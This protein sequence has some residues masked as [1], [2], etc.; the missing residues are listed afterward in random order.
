MIDPCILSLI[1][2]VITILVALLSH[3]IVLAMCLGI[4]SGALILEHSGF[5]ST[6]KNLWYYFYITFS[7]MERLKIALFLLLV[8][9]LL[10]IISHSGAYI[11][12]AKKLAKYLNSARKVRL[13]TFILGIL[14]FFDD[15][16]SVLIAGTSMRSITEEKKI[17]PALMAYIVDS[18]ATVVSIT[19]L[20]TWSAFESSLMVSSAQAA[21]IKKTAVDLLLSSLPY[22]ICTYCGIFLAFLV[23]LTGKWF[24]KRFEHKELQ[25]KKEE[26]IIGKGAGF[27]HVFI[28]IIT[29]ISCAIGGL[30]YSGYKKFQSLSGSEVNIIN[31][32]GDAPTINILIISTVVSLLICIIL[33]KKDRVMPDGTMRKSF[34]TGMKHMVSASLL[35]IL[36][37]GLSQISGDLGTG[38]YITHIFS[39]FIGAGTLPA[40]ITVI[41]SLV[42]IATGISWSSMAILMPIAYDM[43]LNKGG[44]ELLAIMGGAVISGSILGGLL[45]PYSDTSVMASS[46]FKITTIYHVK[47]QFPQVMTVFAVSLMAYL[48]IGFGVNLWAV[49]LMAAGLLGVV[50]WR[51]AK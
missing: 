42:T 45:I 48:L 2:T 37:K 4:A 35:I 7:D 10:G 13:T 43:A 12:F 33:L 38:I 40:I 18:V 20:S 22:H 34:L 26:I 41:A 50:H 27:S 6:I 14:I 36:S 39:S 5:I 25:E 28:P 51:F 29:L 3:R 24:G 15:Y 8:G 1:P 23:A 44:G 11:E 19:I 49:Y 16:A 47:T 46:A 31:L 32:L 30:L 17:S 9:G 21:G